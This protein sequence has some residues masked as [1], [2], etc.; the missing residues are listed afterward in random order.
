MRM[1]VTTIPSQDMP[2]SP[3]TSSGWSVA[4]TSNP[5]RSSPCATAARRSASSSTRM[6]RPRAMPAVRYAAAS[7]RAGA[8]GSAS[9]NSAP[10]SGAAPAVS[11]PPKSWTML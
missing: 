10:P 4:R 8:C 5:A 6:M 3:G 1:S 2:T 11:L 9:R 7:A